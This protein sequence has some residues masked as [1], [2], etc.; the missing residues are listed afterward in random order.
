[1]DALDLARYRTV[2]NSSVGSA[3]YLWYLDFNGDGTVDNNDYTF[4]RLRLGKKV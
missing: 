4:A 1:M 3:N 2:L